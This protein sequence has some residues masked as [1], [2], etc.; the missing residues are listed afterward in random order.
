MHCIFCVMLNDL[1]DRKEYRA[2]LVLGEDCVYRVV[3]SVHGRDATDATGRVVPRRVRVRQA[4]SVCFHADQRLSEF[5]LASAQHTSRPFT[6][7]PSQLRTAFKCLLVQRRHPLV[8][9]R[10]VVPHRD[11]SQ[12]APREASENPDSII[13]QLQASP[14]MRK[15]ADKPEALRALHDF[16]Q[17]LRDSGLSAEQFRRTPYI[18]CVLGLSS[19][20]PG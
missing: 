19:S 4:H 14:I 1:S 5:R 13:S 7:L 2:N 6:M 11:F 15:L 10:P 18:S 8:H 3:V 16:A 20:G 9:K 17:L 12:S